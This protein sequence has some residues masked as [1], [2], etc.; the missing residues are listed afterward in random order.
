MKQSRKVFSMTVS[1]KSLCLGKYKKGKQVRKFEMF[2]RLDEARKAKKNFMS[3]TII[4]D[5]R[6]T[7][8]SVVILGGASVRDV[9]TALG[10]S[11][12]RITEKIYIHALESV[13]NKGAAYVLSNLLE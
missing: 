7:C 2:T 5:L 11:D 3:K 1:Q 10:H 13:S 4:H 8:A 12:T 9:A 6:H